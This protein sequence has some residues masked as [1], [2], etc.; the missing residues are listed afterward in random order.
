MVALNIIIIFKKMNDKL[1]G[2]SRIFNSYEKFKKEH[3]TKFD[4]EVYGQLIES[5]GGDESEEFAE[6]LAEKQAEY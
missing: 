5:H 2:K 1:K 4:D 3:H 6:A